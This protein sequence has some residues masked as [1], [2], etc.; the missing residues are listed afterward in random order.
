ME[1]AG[2]VVI[3]GASSGI[4]RCAAT[5]FARQGWRVGLIARGEAGLRAASGD[6]ERQGAMAATAQADVVD[7][8]VLEE[9]A[10]RIERALGPIDVWVNCAGNGTYGRFLD[11]PAAEF[12]RVTDVTY[13]GTVNGTRVALRRMLPRDSGHIVNVCSAV[14]FRGMP[15]LSSYSG[16]KH[17][18]RGFGQSV[19]AELAQD[20]SR[21]R[22]T[23]IFPPAVNTPFCDHAVSHMGRPGRPMAPVYQPEIVAEAILIAAVSG[24]REMPVSFTTVLFAL[25]TRL[26]P[27]L[28]DRAIDRLGYAAQLSDAGTLAKPHSTT[29][30][31]AADCASP[32]RGRFD[33]EA[34]SRSLH[35]LMLRVFAKFSAQGRRRSQAASRMTPVRRLEDEG[36]S[37]IEETA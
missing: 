33:A 1:T 23:T 15:L 22:L 10:T 29:L 24:A 12:Q 6:V 14:A 32:V 11:T 13:Q 26:V 16:A 17:A 4:G 31:A 7:L 28:V 25:C 21:V 27:R 18:V 8:D 5:L 9:A 37:V 19:C 34:R 2:V 20:G 30:F 36:T 35:V 3:T